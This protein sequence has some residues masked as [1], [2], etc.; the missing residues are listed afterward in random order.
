MSKTVSRGRHI[1][2]KHPGI[3]CR[4]SAGKLGR[5]IDIRGDGGYVVETP[6]IH[7]NGNRYEWITKPSQIQLADMPE[8]MIELLREHETYIY[9]P[10]AGTGH[11]IS[12]ERN[13][14]LTKMAGAM[15]RKGFDE[16]QIF[17][18][19]EDY[20]IKKCQPALM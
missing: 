14:A 5:G 7:P 19:L 17:L 13:N 4:S 15:R 12:G 20:N 10:Q 1:Y 11:I 16:D 9:E 6:S 18:A 2:F 3:E 8:W